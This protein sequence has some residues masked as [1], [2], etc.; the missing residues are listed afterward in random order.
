MI[1]GAEADAAVDSV[2]EWIALQR[3]SNSNNLERIIVAF[4]RV[5][6]VWANHWQY[7][8]PLIAAA[9]AILR[10]PESR[11]EHI[12]APKTFGDGHSIPST[13]VFLDGIIDVEYKVS[14]HNL[15]RLLD[16]GCIVVGLS[17]GRGQVRIPF[18]S[19]AHHGKPQR[20][21]LDQ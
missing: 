9:T 1:I 17:K 13:I 8:S 12:P 2:I 19:P 21:K 20:Y 16:V 14:K 7:P 4:P 3:T 15:K 18:N 11:R 6:T 5:K 10:N